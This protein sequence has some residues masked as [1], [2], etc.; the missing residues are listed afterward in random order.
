ME[1]ELHFVFDCGALQRIREESLKNIPEL[2][3][4]TDNVTKLK[5]LCKMPYRFGTM[6]KN[7]WQTCENFL[8]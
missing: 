1:D 5:Y 8:K 3:N 4:I 7:L 6:L 2:T